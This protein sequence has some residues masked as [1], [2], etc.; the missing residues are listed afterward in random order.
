LAKEA[1]GTAK[2]LQ[3]HLDELNE[4][5]DKYVTTDSRG[6]LL[7]A[8]QWLDLL[9]PPH[10]SDSP[11]LVRARTALLALEKHLSGIASAE[12]K[13]WRSRLAD[14]LLCADLLE[15]WASRY[16]RILDGLYALRNMAVHVGAFAMPGDFTSA[17]AAVAFAD[18]AL[19]FLGNWYEVARREQLHD[20]LGMSAETVIESLAVR[21][22]ELVAE[23]RSLPVA[24]SLNISHLTSPTSNG[25]DR[26]R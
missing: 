15:Q 18:V 9:Q 17:R 12:L 24:H 13:E 2:L 26:A 19:E 16:S 5:M 10:E 20:K 7:D 11:E 14:P 3:Q 23:M 21:C 22:R 4:S 8:N 6:H 25:R 1:R